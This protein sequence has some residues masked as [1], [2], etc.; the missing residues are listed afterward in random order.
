MNDQAKYVSRPWRRFLRFSVRGLI[1]VAL[2]VGGW[3]GCWQVR[4]ARIQREAVAAVRNAGGSV[5]YNWEPANG[6]PIAGA[7]PWAPRKFVDL[8]GIDYF[9]HVTHVKFFRSVLLA[10]V[11]ELQRRLD[12]GYYHP[13]LRGK[14]DEPIAC[15]LSEHVDW[16]HTPNKALVPLLKGLTQLADLDLRSIDLGGDRLELLAEFT[17]LSRLDLGNTRLS[18]GGLVHL[19]SLTKLTRLKLDHNHISDAGLVHLKALRHL[20]EFYLEDTQVTDAGVRELKQALPN[21]TIVR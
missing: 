7:T 6:K 21:V 4:S 9:G 15:G 2:A 20:S 14:S 10:K 1:V 3:L 19:R 5:A 13:L 16:P 17:D 11:D 8:L 12:A 18:D